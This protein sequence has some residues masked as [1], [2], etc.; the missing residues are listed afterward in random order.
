[1]Q[2]SAIYLNLRN[3]KSIRIELQQTVA[4]LILEDKAQ[5]GE[6]PIC[7]NESHVCHVRTLHLEMRLHVHTSVEAKPK[8]TC[9][10]YRHV[11]SLRRYGSKLRNLGR[12]RGE[13]TARQGDARRYLCVYRVMRM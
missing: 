12:Q 3:Y 5:K 9:V 2:I 7:N 4:Y 6:D 10:L 8:T 13:I 11:I 1:M